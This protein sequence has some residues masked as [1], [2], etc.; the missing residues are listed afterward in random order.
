MDKVEKTILSQEN[1]V[2]EVTD[3]GNRDWGAWDSEC[4]GQVDGGSGLQAGG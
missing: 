2:G 1:Y 4:R 3:I